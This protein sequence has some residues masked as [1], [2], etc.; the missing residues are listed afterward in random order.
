MGGVGGDLTQNADI[1]WNNFHDNSEQID[2]NADDE[3]GYSA[4]TFFNG[5]LN[6]V[7]W[8]NNT[9]SNME[10]GFKIVSTSGS[11]IA[12]VTTDNNS[13]VGFHRIAIEHQ[14]ASNQT[15]NNVN[16]YNY[17]GQPFNPGYYTFADSVPLFNTGYPGETTTWNV[18]ISSLH[19]TTGGYG[20]GYEVWGNGLVVNNN[21]LEGGQGQGTTYGSMSLG[22][23]DGAVLVNNTFCGLDPY[24]YSIGVDSQAGT[25][26]NYTISPNSISLNCPT[27]VVPT[28][29]ISPASG[30][31]NSPPTV[32]I[33]ETQPGSTIYY[34]TDG[35]TPTADSTIYTGPFTPASVPV[36]I[37]A[38]AQWGVGAN[39]R[40]SFPSGYGYVPSD[41]ISATYSGSGNTWYV[42]QNGS[43]S[44]PCTSASP[45]ATP[46]YAVNN[47]ANPGDTVSVAPGTYDYGS[48]GHLKLTAAGTAGKPITVSCQVRG[49]CIITNSETGNDTV[50]WLDGAYETFSGFTVTAS[51]TVYNGIFVDAEQCQHHAKHRSWDRAELHRPEWRGR[52]RPIRLRARYRDRFESDL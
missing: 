12:N 34:T 22:A 31:Q 45:C 15:I 52:H 48:S 51:S 9:V 32:T 33:A 21:L 40:I 16:S 8:N 20:I 38:I 24:T 43:D 30:P 18:S 35:S 36:T 44:N 4:A 19:G 10:Q 27:L 39:Q 11:Y 25:P 6:H 46:D 29:T 1:S 47:K 50:V 14:T 13:F 49:Q 17:F 42:S 41:V 28:P 7:T 37:N 3:G 23:G 5:S 26:T 2:A